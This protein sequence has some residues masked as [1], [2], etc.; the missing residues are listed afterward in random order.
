LE[1][2]VSLKLKNVLNVNVVNMSKFVLE[3]NAKLQ[4]FHVQQKLLNAVD[5][6]GASA[7]I[8]VQV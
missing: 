8:N 6:L 3:D 2:A 1:N 7:L 4:E 5:I